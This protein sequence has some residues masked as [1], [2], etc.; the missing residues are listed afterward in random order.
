MGTQRKYIYVTSIWPGLKHSIVE[1]EA[2]LYTQDREI[3]IESSELARIAGW[4][5]EI[6]NHSPFM[7][8]GWLSRSIDTWEEN[9]NWVLY[10]TRE[11]AELAAIAYLNQMV[12]YD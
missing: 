8:P 12:D 10:D 7:N 6:R 5:S 9:S 4:H 3:F 11:E 2:V 1:L